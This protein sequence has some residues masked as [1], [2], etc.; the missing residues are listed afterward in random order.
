M[1]KPKRRISRK[2][3]ALRVILA[4]KAGLPDWDAVKAKARANG[5]WKGRRPKPLSELTKA[6][7]AEAARR[8]W[9]RPT[10]AA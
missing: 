1:P 9:A 6:R 3:E 5:L 7:M 10:R 2:R 8:R 4:A